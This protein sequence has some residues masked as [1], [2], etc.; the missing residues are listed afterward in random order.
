VTVTSLGHLRQ[1][2]H[3]GLGQLH[4]AVRTPEN[5]LRLEIN[6]EKNENSWCFNGGLMGFNGI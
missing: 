4:L 3:Q 6:Q 1:L 5:V 2:L